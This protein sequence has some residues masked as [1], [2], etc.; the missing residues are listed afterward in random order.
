[1]TMYEQ[2]EKKLKNDLENGKYDRYGQVMKEDVCNAL[3]TFCDQDEEFAQAVVQG[4]SLS[5][6]MAAV[7]KN[8]KGNGISDMV[9]YGA[10]VQFYFPGADIAVKMTID[11]C[12]SV[13]GEGP[14][15]E[16]PSGMVLDLSDFF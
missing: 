13:R 14:S 7:A 5:E 15:P 1:M 4:G 10:A 2:A 12:A 11:L 6:C 16:K 3:L 8:I 9:A